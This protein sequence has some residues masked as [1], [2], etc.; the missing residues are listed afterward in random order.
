MSS[1]RT[2]EERLEQAIAVYRAEFGGQHRGTR[3][4]ARLDEITS[5]MRAVLAQIERHIGSLPQRKRAV[6]EKAKLWTAMLVK[7]RSAIVAEQAKPE[8]TPERLFIAE[9]GERANVSTAMLRARLHPGAERVDLALLRETI[10]TLA[11]CERDMIAR[12]PD[13]PELWMVNNLL[14]VRASLGACR[15]QDA[16]LSKSLNG[17]PA[18]ERRAFAVQLGE[19]LLFFLDWEGKFVTTGAQR[20]ARLRHAAATLRILVERARKVAALA[21]A[22][23]GAIARMISRAELL[24]SDHAALVKERADGGEGAIESL[25]R[26][27][28]SLAKLYKTNF[29]GKARATAPLPLLRRTLYRACS[30]AMQASDLAAECPN[31][32]T[33]A[34]SRRCKERAYLYETEE[35]AVTEAQIGSER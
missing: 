29:A 19:D 20:P 16:E 30:V 3:D 2:L 18:R 25:E 9:P 35:L 12:T 27:L 32:R 4:L 10:E 1:A 13:R 34:L 26:E 31:D 33:A 28:T 7:E 22:D 5:E 14:S 8:R 15:A 24:E 21:G 17:G 6:F 11:E 23:D